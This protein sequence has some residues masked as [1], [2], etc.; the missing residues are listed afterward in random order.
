M[1][2]LLD[3]NAIQSFPE[4][5]I[6]A[7]QRFANTYGPAAYVCRY[8]HCNKATDGFDTLKKRGAHEAA[9]QRKF[10]CADSSCVSFAAGFTSRNALNRHNEKW[11]RVVTRFTPLLVLLPDNPATR[12][13]GK[14]SSLRPKQ[15]TSGPRLWSDAASGSSPQT[16][17]AASIV[18]ANNRIEDEI[19][20]E[21]LVNSGFGAAIER[22]RR[23]RNQDPTADRS[24]TLQQRPTSIPLRRRQ[25]FSK[26]NAK[27]VT[28]SQDQSSDWDAK[29]IPEEDL[30]G[31]LVIPRKLPTTLPPVRADAILPKHQ[32]LA[33]FPLTVGYKMKIFAYPEH[34][35][36]ETASH[37]LSLPEGITSFRI[38]NRREDST[39]LAPIFCYL[40][41]YVDNPPAR[42]IIRREVD[43]ITSFALDSGTQA[44]EAYWPYEY[45]AF[46]AGK[47]FIIS[48]LRALPKL[49]LVECFNNPISSENIA[50]FA[51]LLAGQ[52]VSAGPITPTDLDVL[53]QRLLIPAGIGCLVL[54]PDADGPH[55][56]RQPFREIKYSV[57]VAA[58][59]EYP[60]PPTVYLLRR[61]VVFDILYSEK[62]IK[63]LGTEHE[64]ELG[65]RNDEPSWML[66]VAAKNTDT[67]FPSEDDASQ[68]SENHF[69]T[70][71]EILPY[72]FET[73][74]ST[75]S[76]PIGN[77]SVAHREMVQELDQILGIGPSYQPPHGDD[78]F[79]HPEESVGI[80]AM[81]DRNAKQIQADLQDSQYPMISLPLTPAKQAEQK[82]RK[83][84]EFV[85]MGLNP[86]R[87]ECEVGACFT[88]GVYERKNFARHCYCKHRGGSCN[89]S[90]GKVQE[91]QSHFRSTHFQ[92]SKLG[93]AAR[94]K[95]EKCSHQ[96]H[97]RG[98]SLS[99][100]C[101]NCRESNHVSS[102]IV[103]IF[104]PLPRPNEMMI[105]STRRSII[106]LL[107]VQPLRTDQ[108]R[109]RLAHLSEVDFEAAL[110]RFY[111]NLE[112]GTWM[113]TS[114]EW[115]KIDILH[116][117][118]PDQQH[119]MI[120]IKRNE[121]FLMSLKSRQLSYSLDNA[122][123]GS[124][125]SGGHRHSPSRKPQQ[126]YGSS[127]QERSHNQQLLTPQTTSIPSH[128]SY[129]VPVLNSPGVATLNTN[130]VQSS[131]A[132]KR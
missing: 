4:L 13:Y 113:L 72:L 9:H 50:Q 20:I 95:C 112:D 47:K 3:A 100:R 94:S 124:Q 123:G 22:F 66:D 96:W 39:W 128:A 49:D 16:N 125:S 1:E 23:K 68:S 93:K 122:K 114:D 38:F 102:K 18:S 33:R 17:G 86:Y 106:H 92:F 21:P 69:Q 121:E 89:E 63:A 53:M 62:S 67:R 91:L 8:I 31:A 108:L 60:Q 26:L 19:H 105:D 87:G 43:H 65:S 15:G 71:E 126:H 85:N 78:K 58:S 10:R 30:Q 84:C 75:M 42:R 25:G 70:V 104:G 12:I 80:N 117:G 97:E 111:I 77:T 55:W 81:D 35:G 120:N 129:Y 127:T 48:I 52:N 24:S 54:V 130:T 74:H 40:E 45:P 6:R 44:T 115:K 5:D 119:V 132:Q 51:K 36:A 28:P 34:F 99:L 107:A 101:P 116:F 37:L 103:G 46:D 57:S 27:V 59:R 7:L 29:S 110:T 109:K 2:A 131:T 73:P 76:R 32:G 82:E 118:T 98:D 83:S 64:G 79:Q 56:D 90:F 88:I 11:H 61:G 41:S 14:S